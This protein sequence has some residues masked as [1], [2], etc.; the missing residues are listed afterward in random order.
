MLVVQMAHA[1]DP[2]L[3]VV[4]AATLIAAFAAVSAFLSLRHLG[5]KMLH[6]MNALS[7]ERPTLPL[8]SLSWPLVWLAVF[9]NQSLIPAAVFCTFCFPVEWSG[10]K[11]W[12]RC[13]RVTHIQSSG[14]KKRACKVLNPDMC[15][16]TE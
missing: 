7:P 6:L 10:F 12:K 5:H 9:V 2:R 13:G 15:H 3:R 8:N 14:Q 11:Y 16:D 4:H 1:G